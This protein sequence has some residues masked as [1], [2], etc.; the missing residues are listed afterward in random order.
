MSGTKLVQGQIVLPTTELP[1]KAAEVVIQ[2]E[3]VSRAD[4]PSTVVGEQRQVNVPLRPG[5]I[6]PFA[7]EV[8]E[9]LIDQRC[10][11][12][13]RVHVDVPGSGDVQRGDLISTQSFAVLTRGNPNNIR[14]AVKLL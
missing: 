13:I 8:P 2:V 10:S 1:P 12:S 11:Y 6:I 14:V 7:V 3:D 9:E 5:A 4:A